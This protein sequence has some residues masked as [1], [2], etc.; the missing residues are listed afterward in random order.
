MSLIEQEEYKFK[1]IIKFVY[2]DVVI[3]K[4]KKERHELNARR[5]K[6]NKKLG[7]LKSQIDD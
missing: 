3:D 4:E 6:E 1:W 7:S 5:A 2:L